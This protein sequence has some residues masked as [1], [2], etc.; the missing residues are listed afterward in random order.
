MDWIPG[1]QF[2]E[3]TEGVKAPPPWIEV[4]KKKPKKDPEPWV[5]KGMT[6]EEYIRNGGYPL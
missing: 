5:K 4:K 3:R 6:Q 1:Y 2:M